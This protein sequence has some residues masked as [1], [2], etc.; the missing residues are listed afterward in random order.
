MMIKQWLRSGTPMIWLHAGALALHDKI[1]AIGKDDIGAINYRLEQLR[2]K[3]RALELK[4]TAT[5]ENALSGYDRAKSCVKSLLI[6]AP[7]LSNDWGP[8]HSSGLAGGVQYERFRFPTTN[9]S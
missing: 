4:D 7:S 8:L 6:L 2:R 9:R 1:W 5:P 3:R